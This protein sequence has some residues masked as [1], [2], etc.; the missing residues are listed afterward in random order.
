MD[1]TLAKNTLDETFV[2]WT[3]LGGLTLQH[4]ADE[5][6]GQLD[7]VEQTYVFSDLLVA[8]AG[9]YTKGLYGNNYVTKPAF[10]GC[11]S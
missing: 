2:G 5:S 7:M 9:Y 4:I 11:K 1:T 3:E 10:F 6:V 8:K